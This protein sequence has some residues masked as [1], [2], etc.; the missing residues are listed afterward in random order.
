[1]LNE[2]LESGLKV[3]RLKMIMKMKMD[4]LGA[5]NE[6]MENAGTDAKWRRSEVAFDSGACDSVVNSDELLD[7]TVRDT[8]TSKAGEQFCIS[9]R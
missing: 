6:T 2:K 5:V 8:V 4:R 9:H 1:M 3:R 7:H